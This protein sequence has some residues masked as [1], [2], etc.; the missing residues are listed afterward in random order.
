MR[1]IP[2]PHIPE[3][4]PAMVSARKVFSD[5]MYSSGSREFATEIDTF[6]GAVTEVS[7]VGMIH[8]LS[9]SPARIR[10]VPSS[11][12][13]AVKDPFSDLHAGESVWDIVS[14]PTTLYDTSPTA[15]NMMIATCTMFKVSPPTR[16]L[17][18][19]MI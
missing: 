8:L 10:R 4:A 7:D 11:A 9:I 14:N 15:K 17:H 13:T 18:V 16:C 12:V 5:Q 2:T 3:T 19:E 1:N 6:P